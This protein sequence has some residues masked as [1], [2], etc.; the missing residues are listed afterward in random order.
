M[1]LTDP[2]VFGVLLRM[3]YGTLQEAARPRAAETIG[4]LLG[5]EGGRSHP[6]IAC[7][8]FARGREAARDL[9]DAVHFIADLHGRHPGM[10]DLAREKPPSDGRPPTQP[11]SPNSQRSAW[12]RARI[13]MPASSTLY[14]RSAF[15]KSR[16][17]AS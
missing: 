5:D 12:F 9:A 17:T 6:Y 3:A 8:I 15:R 1:L 16:S 14:S 11:S 10:I 4:A 7:N 2:V 13:S